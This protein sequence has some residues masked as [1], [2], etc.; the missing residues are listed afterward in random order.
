MR[1]ARLLSSAA[2]CA[3]LAASGAAAQ[4]GSSDDTTRL[5]EEII[6]CSGLSD[7]AA[8]LSCYDELAQPL[9]GLEP[10]DGS[11]G[12]AALHSFTG[13]DDW[14][15]QVL[16]FSA[17][18]RVVWQGQGSLLTVEL[19]TSQG[20]LVRVVGNQIGEGGGRS[21]VLQPGSYRLAVRGLGG[22]RLQVIDEA[23]NGGN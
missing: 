4:T 6:D 23:E 3:A 7:D 16:D 19:H 5:A 18:W 14:D 22:W 1:A 2:V 8:R 20:E 11:G 21:E 15:S 17:P 13:K 10:A 9:L 12:V